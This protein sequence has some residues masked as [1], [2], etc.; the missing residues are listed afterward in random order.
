MK[1]YDPS[2]WFWS[3][4][5]DKSRFWS[6]A[7]RAYV[8]KLPE[9]AGLTNIA[10]E[11][12]L[13]DVLREQCPQGLPL[14]TLAEMQA[15][16]EALVIEHAEAYGSRLTAGYPSHE[17]ES[18]TA[19]IGEARAIEAGEADPAKFPIIATECSFTGNSATDTAASVLAK[20]LPFSKASGAISGIRQESVRRIR[21][22]TDAT[23]I[24]AALAWAKAA[25][26]AAFS[27]I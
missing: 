27:S 26:D 22:A 14:P 4:G 8:D 3:V 21:A 1:N 2:N 16:A 5:G 6:S 9:D 23:G 11:G 10:S 19:K 20:A 7:A 15:N 13:W 17:R 12:E 25:A 18:W 24:E